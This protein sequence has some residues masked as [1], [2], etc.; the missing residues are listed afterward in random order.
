[1]STSTTKD[2]ATRQAEALQM[3]YESLSNAIGIVE[4]D[5]QAALDDMIAARLLLITILQ[6]LPEAGLRG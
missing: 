6:T 2:A 4:T 5:V 1:M 3:A